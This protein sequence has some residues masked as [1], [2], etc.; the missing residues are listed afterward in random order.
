MIKRGN[1]KWKAKECLKVWQ[2]NEKRFHKEKEWMKN[3]KYTEKEI[4]CLILWNNML[5]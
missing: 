2:G 4:V 1:G 5:N 3:V